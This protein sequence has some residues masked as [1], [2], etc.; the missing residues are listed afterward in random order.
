MPDVRVRKLLLSVVALGLLLTCAGLA[1]AVTARSGD[2][3]G[4]VR[5]LLLTALLLLLPVFVYMIRLRGGARRAAR[6]RAVAQRQALDSDAAA[7]RTPEGVRAAGADPPAA[8]P[9]AP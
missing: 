8:P 5:V 6:A 4:S 3:F 2:D 7:L 1:Q 9:A